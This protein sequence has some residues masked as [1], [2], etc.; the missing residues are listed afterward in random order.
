VQYLVILRLKP[1][2][3]GEKLAPLL[4]PEAA[5]A[6][7]M[8][9]AGALRSIHLIEGPVGAVLMFEAGHEKEAEA[10]VGRLPLVEADLVTVEVLPLVPFT[11]FAA[12]FA[13]PPSGER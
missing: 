12:L 6:W 7:E 4:K 9:A 11:G 5:A 2:A 13:S 3:S 1:E 8:L 10:H